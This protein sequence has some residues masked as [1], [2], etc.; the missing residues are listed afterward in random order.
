MGKRASKK[1]SKK[2]RKE[3]ILYRELVRFLKMKFKE[4]NMKE[5]KTKKKEEA[6]KKKKEK[7]EDMSANDKILELERAFSDSSLDSDPDEPTGAAARPV[8]VW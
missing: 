2:E 4:D 5:W 8:F 7:K 3:K 1:L 6:Q